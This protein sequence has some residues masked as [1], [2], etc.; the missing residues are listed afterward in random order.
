MAFVSV[1]VEDGSTKE[2]G[3]PGTRAAA[4]PDAPQQ[5]AGGMTTATYN[6]NPG[7]TR[8]VFKDGNL[9]DRTTSKQTGINV[10]ESSSVDQATSLSSIVQD[11]TGDRYSITEAIAYG[12]VKQTAPGV[13]SVTEE[14]KAAFTAAGNTESAAPASDQG[15]SNTNTKTT[16]N[17]SAPAADP[18]ATEASSKFVGEVV[19][20]VGDAQALYAVQA[21]LVEG[22]DE[23]A[24]KIVAEL[25][26]ASGV[27]NFTEQYASLV[28][29]RV[30]AARSLV[31]AEVGLDAAEVQAFE[32]HLSQFP[33]SLRTVREA[34][35]NG[36][37]ATVLKAAQAY[38]SDVLFADT[39]IDPIQDLRVDG[40]SVEGRVY[41]V[42]GRYAVELATGERAWLA[43][44]KVSCIAPEDR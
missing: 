15:E 5:K 21:A 11:S 12:F 28:T 34:I 25:A 7:Q 6:E 4:V 38:H 44:Q 20:K 10:N 31:A 29:D 40:R 37:K 3:M 13:F 32:N 2:T 33:E 17:E 14:G 19:G 35:A 26:Q 24:E 43:D 42:N 39:E 1:N 22:K 8:V 18:F 41:R 16:E 23:A 27:E 30:N 9:I 36:D